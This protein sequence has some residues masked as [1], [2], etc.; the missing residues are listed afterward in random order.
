MKLNQKNKEIVKRLKLI[1][2]NAKIQLKK[3]KGL[4]TY[5][6]NKKNWNLKKYQ[7][8]KTFLVNFSNKRGISV[9]K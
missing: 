5:R 8:A 6:N 7:K 2:I 3:I 4:K 1:K 9:W